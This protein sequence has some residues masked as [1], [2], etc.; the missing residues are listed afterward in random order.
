MSKSNINFREGSRSEYLAQFALSTIG[1]IVPVPRE[2]DYMLTDL[3]VH[4]HREVGS[5]SARAAVP[6]GQ[7]LAV[8][9]KSSTEPLYL[10][11]ESLRTVARSQIP[12]FIAVC[13]RAGSQLDV[14][15]TIDRHFFRAFSGGTPVS[16]DE[17]PASAEALKDSKGL[18]L[19]PPIVSVSL[20]AL[21]HESLDRRREARRSFGSVMATWAVADSINIA[22]LAESSSW[23]ARPSRYETGNA[24][25][26]E[27]IEAISVT[28]LVSAEKLAGAA[29]MRLMG[30]R[31]AIE[32]GIGG[33]VTSETREILVREIQRISSAL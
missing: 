10:D 17:R 1:F 21:E 9:V 30:L 31:H 13:D 23:V 20:A 33:S 26:I 12:W 4:L 32:M 24:L 25:D 19:G 27:Q 7:A 11:A 29:T 6:L 5:G 22:S 18:H 14:Y 8:Q 15:Q 3:F 28:G 2:E 16:F